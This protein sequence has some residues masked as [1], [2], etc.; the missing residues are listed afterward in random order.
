MQIV[1]L[2]GAAICLITPIGGLLVQLLFRFLDLRD[3]AK[4]NDSQR[5]MRHIEFIRYDFLLLII[6]PTVNIMLT[7]AKL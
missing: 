7:S 2:S 1:K 4:A 6:G 5:R 3:F